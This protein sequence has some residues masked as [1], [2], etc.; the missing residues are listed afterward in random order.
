MCSYLIARSSSV[1][2]FQVTERRQI[3][4]KFTPPSGHEPGTAPYDPS[5]PV[6][7]QVHSSISKTLQ[8]LRHKELSNLQA[9]ETVYL[10]SVLL[11]SPYQDFEDTLTAWRTLSS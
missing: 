1:L 7:E 4:S 10:D 11:H 3:Q 8:N 6:S 5:S 9:A 2:L